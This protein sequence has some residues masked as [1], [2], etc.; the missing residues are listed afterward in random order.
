MR[1]ERLLLKATRVGVDTILQQ[2][3]AEH[4]PELEQAVR[5]GVRQ[6]VLSYAYALED[7]A[8]KLDPIRYR[9]HVHAVHLLPDASNDEEMLPHVSARSR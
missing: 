9:K 1:H 6:A 4:S 2:L 7:L 5:D 8:S 3:P